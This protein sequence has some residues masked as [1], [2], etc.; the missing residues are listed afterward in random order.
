MAEE[1]HKTSHLEVP[2]G[3]EQ[4]PWKDT[5]SP[6]ARSSKEDIHVLPPTNDLKS[7]TILK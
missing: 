7:F 6:F 4:K 1:V 2:Y 5:L 3:P